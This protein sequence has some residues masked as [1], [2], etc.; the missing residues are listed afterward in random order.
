[1]FLSIVIPAYNE[2]KRIGETLDKYL[3]FYKEAGV[4]FI[5]ALNGCRDNTLAVVKKYAENS[6]QKIRYFEIGEPGKGRAIREG[7]KIAN[8]EL[9]S[10]VDADGSTDPAE[11]N[12]LVKLI[13][14][15]DGAIASRWKRG[16]QVINRK[17]FRKII[18]IGFILIVRMLLWLPFVDTQC[19]AKVFKKKVIKQI[20]PKL[21]I[22]NTA[23][24]VEI[25]YFA[26]RYNYNIVEMPSR[27]VD[28][29]SSVVVGSPGKLFIN[30]LTMFFTLIVIRIRR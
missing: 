6:P 13:N 24:D 1:M 12:K 26:D 23:F 27:W 8:G 5:I 7:F 30:I 18:S 10:F 25:L 22:N 3:Q 21:K 9:I 28:K 15:F 4:E 11:F 20:L 14:G 16:S 17:T 19:G 2:E 29:S